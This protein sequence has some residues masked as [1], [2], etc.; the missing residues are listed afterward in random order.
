MT[1][2]ETEAL[3]VDQILPCSSEEIGQMWPELEFR[4]RDVDELLASTQER[5]GSLR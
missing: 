2:E 4:L 1:L 5:I 3:A